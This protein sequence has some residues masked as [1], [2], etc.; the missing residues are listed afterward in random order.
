[1]EHRCEFQ[2]LMVLEGFWEPGQVLLIG[3]SLQGS[4]PEVFWKGAL[5]DLGGLDDTNDRSDTSPALPA[6]WF[7][8][9]SAYRTMCWMAKS[10]LREPGYLRSAEVAEIIGVT[11]QTLLNWLRRGFITE[12]ERNPASGYRRWTEQDVEAIRRFIRDRRL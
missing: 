2:N 3:L 6:L 11:K 10:R 1:M 9:S 7:A 4:E 12:P 5:A 8:L